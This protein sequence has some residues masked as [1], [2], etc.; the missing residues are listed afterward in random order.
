MHEDMMDLTTVLRKAIPDFDIVIAIPRAGFMLGS[1]IAEVYGKPL[2]TLDKFLKGEYWWRQGSNKLYPEETNSRENVGADIVLPKFFKK[3]LIV[4]DTVSSGNHMKMFLKELREKCP[5]VDFKVVSLYTTDAGIKYCDLYCKKISFTHLL[6]TN[7]SIYSRC[8]PPHLIAMDMDGVISEDCPIEIARSEG[9]EEYIEWLKNV[10]P[11]MNFHFRI[12]YIVTARLEKYRKLTERWLR[13]H[14]VRYGTLIM[15][16]ADGRMSTDHAQ[17]KVDELKKLPDGIN[18]YESST[19]QAKIIYHKTGIQTLSVEDMVMFGQKNPSYEY[20]PVFE[21]MHKRMKV[22]VPIV[23]V[24]EDKKK[25]H[26][27]SS[28][29]PRGYWE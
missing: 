3:A 20:H 18:F 6:E 17:F 29:F 22:E 19:A 26:Q 21:G 13:E 24:V 4:E 1:L 10:K 23:P 7:L 9:D 11:Y 12:D 27:P 15:Q 28:V 14:G 25:Y 5:D 8:A 16:K 2:T